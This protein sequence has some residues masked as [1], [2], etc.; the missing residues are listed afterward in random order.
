ML[1]IE[2]QQR[3]IDELNLNCRVIVAELVT[4]CQRFS[5]NH[6]P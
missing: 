3:I 5:G 1:P 2:R 4:L 6:S